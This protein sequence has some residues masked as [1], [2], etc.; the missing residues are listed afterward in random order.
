MLRGLK[1]CQG[2][3]K[4][5]H[6]HGLLLC[7][8]DISN[9]YAAKFQLEKRQSI[10]LGFKQFAHSNPSIDHNQDGSLICRATMVLAGRMIVANW[11]MS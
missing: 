11:R 5:D 4:Y 10:G 8:F 9:T 6:F 2:K 7:G 1:S 3:S